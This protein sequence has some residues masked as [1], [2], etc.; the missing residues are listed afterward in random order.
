MNRTPIWKLDAAP[1]AHPTLE[2]D[3]EVDV[4]IVGGGIT[5]VTAAHLL[6]RAGRRV[7]VLEAHTLGSGTTGHSTGNLYA[8]VD[9]YLSKIRKKFDN[10]TARVVAQSRRA[11]LDQIEALVHEHGLECE[12]RRT[13][14]FLIAET[15][16]MV[17]LVELEH[18]AL[19]DAGLSCER[20]GPS[21]VPLP[22]PLRTA[23]RL[24]NQAQLN[25]LTYVRAL[26]AA[27]VSER[28]AL[29]E[30][31]KVTSFEEQDGACTLETERGA[32][33]RAGAIVMAT[34]TPKGIMFVQTALGPYREYGLA[35]RLNRSSYPPPG[36]YW[37]ME[38]TE[39]RSVRQVRT[40]DGEEY[41]LVLGGPHKVGQAEDNRETLA[42]LEAYVRERFDVAEV[43]HAWG[44]QH[45]R[46]ADALPYIG[47]RHESSNVHIA[48][49]FSTDGLVY[50]TLAA[51][52][53]KE[54]ILGRDSPWAKTYAFNR[55]TPF[56]SAVEWVKE[57]ANVALQYLKAL[58]K[59]VDVERFS[60]VL[61][62]EG[63]L[64]EVDGRRYAAYRAED[65]TLQ[66]VS[67]VCTHLKCI[68]A[69]NHLERTWDCPCHGSRFGTDGT[70]IE[71][72]AIHDLPPIEPEAM[73]EA[74]PGGDGGDDGSSG[75]GSGA[76]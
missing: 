17:E 9:K 2:R 58:P 76:A 30:H 40:A 72:P 10:D 49:G 24:G 68:V 14:F 42:A 12:F 65:G 3:L 69:W 62:G 55:H 63:S 15:D 36:I 21:A 35:A 66:V 18:D 71:G 73:A 27:A 52:L 48:T 54:R 8:P 46:P 43:T 13:P 25:P 26:A 29:Y 51:M 34:H 38:H 70:V 74:S 5:G 47:P 11:A 50:G 7:A 75:S 1:G 64:V 33:V 39:L 41:L 45:Y 6:S 37:V 23:L 31:T 57:N 60:Q 61:P 19:T 32:I 4:A 16:D 28:C 59:R 22:F 44:A 53:L 67:A 20:V 56:K